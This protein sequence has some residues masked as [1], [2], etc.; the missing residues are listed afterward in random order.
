MLGNDS[1]WESNHSEINSIDVDWSP[2]SQF[3]LFDISLYVIVAERK[4]GMT[5]AGILS[6]FYEGKRTGGSKDH[7]EQQSLLFNRWRYSSLVQEY[8]RN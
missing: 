6:T 5:L 1:A 7:K 4:G 2:V 8:G 3:Y